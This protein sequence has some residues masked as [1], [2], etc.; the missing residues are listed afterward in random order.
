[1]VCCRQFRSA[2][3]G[4]YYNDGDSVTRFV[5]ELT[6]NDAKRLMELFE[7]QP[8]SKA[9]QSGAHSGQAAPKTSAKAAARP[10]S[11]AGPDAVCPR[12][13]SIT[14]QPLVRNACLPPPE[15]HALC[16]QHRGPHPPM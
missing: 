4:C 12:A 6:K 9:P 1:M 13:M 14:V 10:A 8:P 2:I 7:K 3:E 16:G 5:F 15:C 11:P